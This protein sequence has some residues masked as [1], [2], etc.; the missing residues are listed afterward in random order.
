MATTLQNLINDIETDLNDNSNA[1][2]EAADIERG[3][4]WVERKWYLS[5][6]SSTLWIIV[7]PAPTA[8]HSGG[9]LAWLRWSV[10]SGVHSAWRSAQ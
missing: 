10:C 1:T 9:R 2:W 3:N 7:Q 6:G 4:D 5:Y 8:V